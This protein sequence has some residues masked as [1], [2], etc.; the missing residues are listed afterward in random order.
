MC[1]QDATA[2]ELRQYME[3]YAQEFGLARIQSNNR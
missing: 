1:E 3:R 2:Q